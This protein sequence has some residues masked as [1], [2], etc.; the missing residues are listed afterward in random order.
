MR[1]A[2]VR[3]LLVAAAT[4]LL[5]ACGSQAP[6]GPEIALSACH[7]VVDAAATPI[8][9]GE[10]AVALAGG[11]LVSFDDRRGTARGSL[12]LVRIDAVGRP[13]TSGDLTGGKPAAFHPHGIGL[14]RGKDETI[15]MVVN[16]PKG[17][18]GPS[19]TVETYRVAADG[20]LAHLRTVRS[21]GHERLNDVLPVSATAFYATNETRA[22]RDNRWR[23]IRDYLFKR[24]DGS[25]IFHDGRQTRDVAT[26]FAF[27]NSVER[28]GEDGLAVSD[29]I[30]GE[31]RWLTGD[32]A[33]GK[34][35]AR[36]TI[37]VGPGP[38]NLTDSGGGLLLG[39]RHD[40][41][42][43][44]KNYSDRSADTSPWSLFRIDL[45]NG[46]T[47]ALKVLGYSKGN[48]LPAAA[49]A[50]PLGKRVFLGTVFDKATI[51]SSSPEIAGSF[52]RS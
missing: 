47:A 22:T 15:L 3:A 37:D 16:H 40:D 1:R 17:W 7:T 35:Q 9:G 50:V 21:P 13:A 8:L 44:F 32:I 5:A 24:G 4:G 10:D 12:R 38:D 19:S 20:A 6:D 41:L 49:V 45:S 52:Q 43:R 39:V 46:R 2:T 33:G 34:P 26:G 11:L 25:L 29:S 27:A 28:V 42:R 30:R 36:S 18:E 51:C 14:W 23:G 48:M 31:I